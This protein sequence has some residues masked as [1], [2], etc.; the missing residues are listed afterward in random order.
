[1]HNINNN[2]V[3]KNNRSQK[4]VFIGNCNSSV[5]ICLIFWFFWYFDINDSFVWKQLIIS[6]KIAMWVWLLKKQEN[7][8]VLTLLSVLGMFLQW[9][10]VIEEF[11]STRKKNTTKKPN[12][13]EFSKSH[14]Q[15]QKTL[16]AVGTNIFVKHHSLELLSIVPGKIVLCAYSSSKEY[17]QRHKLIAI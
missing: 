15:Q 16:P 14:S 7:I 1:M 2:R 4:K 8:E 5:M 13:H 10:I 17:P 9:C 12:P 3:L 6:V 11:S